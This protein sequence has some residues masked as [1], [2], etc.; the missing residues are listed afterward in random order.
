MDIML[1][2]IGLTLILT[3]FKN[4]YG[5]MGRRFYADMFGD[6]TG[7]GFIW[8]IGAIGIVGAGIA[9]IENLNSYGHDG[10]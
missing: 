3:G 2:I 1:I 4:T 5:D 8:W 10:E 7:R 6:G 9:T